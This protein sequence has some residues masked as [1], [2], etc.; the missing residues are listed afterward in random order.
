MISWFEYIRIHTAV[1]GFININKTKN[2]FETPSPY[3]PFHLK[4]LFKK[5]KGGKHFYTLI[6]HSNVTFTAK[7]KWNSNL[8]II[9]SEL[10]WQDIFHV[11]HH[12]IEDNYIFS[13]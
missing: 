4:I 8:N 9:L 12:T 2:S 3:L 1:T 10:N 13:I 6:N 11:C 7:P 5:N